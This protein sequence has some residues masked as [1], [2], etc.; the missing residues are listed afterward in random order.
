MKAPSQNP[1]QV[2]PELEKH[3]LL[4][5]FRIVL[6]LQK[7]WGCHLVDAVSGREFIDLYGFFGSLPVGFNHPWFDQPEVKADLLRAAR[8]KVANSDIYTAAYARFVRTFSR[9]VGLPP[10][11]RYFFIDGGA[12]AVENALKAAMDWKVQ[13]NLSAGKG[14]HGTEIMHF[15]RAFHGRSGYTL[16]ITNTDPVKTRY[17]A[18]FNWP[19]IQAPWINFALP[20]PDRTQEVAQHEALAE[21]QILRCL[22]E[23]GDHI[24]AIITEPIQGEGGDNHFRGEWLRTLRRICDEHDLLLIFDEVQTGMGLTGRN[25]CCEHFDVLPDL[26]VFGKKAQI[27]GVM[28][29]P[30]LDEVP[31]NV[32]RLPGRI[33]STW[34]GNLTD[35]V[36]SRHC[37]RLMET[38]HLVE[39]AAETGRE[40]LEALLAWQEETPSI[41]AVRGRGLMLAFDLPTP[42][43]RERFYE[44]IYEQGLLALRSGERSIRFRPPLDFPAD[45]IPLVMDYLRRQCHA[46]EGTEFLSR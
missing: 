15:E 37:L 3:I 20:D 7:S 18:Q 39:Q 32:F 10:L 36:R 45:N 17:F 42:Q 4:D 6:D 30:R 16:S 24:A 2:L 40:F 41:R 21:A 31:D 22:R 1:I 29:G 28:A 5:G 38:T 26:L 23:R 27:C 9:V 35:M 25:W 43:A 19:R 13:K 8:T 46:M 14:E 12:L 44:G 33:N 34:G 11:E